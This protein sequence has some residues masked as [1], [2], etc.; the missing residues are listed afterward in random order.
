[1]DKRLHIVAFD[2]PFPA[3][4]GGAIDLFYKLKALSELGLKITLHCFEYG[5]GEA[6]ELNKYCQKVYYYK[7]QSSRQNLFSFSP[8][9][10]VSRSS[11]NLLENLCKD[12]APILFEGLHCCFYLNHERLKGR[13]RIVRTHNVEHDYYRHLAAAESSIF[14]RFY[15][16]LE[17]NKLRTY[18]QE[19]AGADALVSISPADTQH[20]TA[21]NPNTFHITAFHTNTEMLIKPDKGSFCLY[22][23]SLGIGENNKAALWLVDEVLNDIDIPVVIAGNNPSLE[24]KNKVAKHPHIILKSE[25]NTEEIHTLIQAAQVNILP[26]FQATGIKLKLLAALFNG[27]HCVVNVPMVENTGLESLCCI[28]KDATEMKSH[29][30]E[31]Y[32]TNFDLAELEKRKKILGIGF[33]NQENAKKFIQIL[34]P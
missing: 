19:L 34:F 20:F 29:I 1:V 26:T 22:H 10:V 31:K 12:K 21:I 3:N 18:E 15:F 32:Q 30:L 4:Y 17:A 7:R 5:R 9:I 2:V 11:P 27:K 33:S 24:L 6:K 28:A 16:E 8:F 13:R 23:G 25:I 14:K